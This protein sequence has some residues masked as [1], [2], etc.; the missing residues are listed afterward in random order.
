MDKTQS[1]STFGRAGYFA[2]VTRRDGPAI[3]AALA[4]ATLLDDGARLDGTVVEAAYAF[5]RPP[6]LKRLGDDG[7]CRVIDPQTLRFT[8][9]RYLETESLMRLPYAPA[10][11]I[12]AEE[13]NESAAREL[14]RGSMAYAQD[15]GTD[16]YLAAGVPLYDRDTENWI[17]HNEQ[18]LAFSCALNGSAALER[19]PLLAQIAPGPKALANPDAIVRRLLDYP[20]DGVYVQALRLNPVVDSVE[21]LARFVQFVAAI[22]DAGFDVLVGRVGAF[23]L[24][25]QALGISVFD[26]GL[27]LAEA[28]DLASLNRPVT[29]RDKER[30]AQKSGGPPGRVYLE[31]LKTTVM[32]KVA[33]NLLGLDSVRHHLTCTL[34]CCRFRALDELPGRARSHYLYTRRREVDRMR[35]LSVAAMRLHET[36]TQLRAA[37]DL[38][39]VLR[40]AAPDAGLPRLDHLDRW[41][42]LLGREQQLALAA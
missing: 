8:G 10:Q 14:A 16:V 36:E 35:S 4:G 33:R 40:R 7:V 20:I 21:K 31:P 18:L 28:H 1:A 32:A 3:E 37:S 29:Q 12:R 11:P 41:L 17:R 5:D 23:G 27:G 15:R 34:G 9:L 26:S 6:L 38:G 19:K 30:R 24:V 25:L 22:R 39:S 42:G 13:F 2:R